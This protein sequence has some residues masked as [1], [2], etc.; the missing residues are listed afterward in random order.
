MIEEKC[1]MS[2]DKTL[3]DVQSECRQ[4]ERFLFVFVFFFLF[5][6]NQR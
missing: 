3:E 6:E 2:V 4:T 5:K 1:P